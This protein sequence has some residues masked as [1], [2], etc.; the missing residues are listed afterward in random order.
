M[1]SLSVRLGGVVALFFAV[2]ATAEGGSLKRKRSLDTS[3]G[4]YCGIYSLYAA[5]RAVDIDVRFEDLVSSKYVGSIQGSSL[6]EL[7]QAARD[8]GAHAEAFEGMTANSLRTA[9]QPIVLHVRRPGYKTAYAH[10]I[11]FLGT[12]G[13]QARIVD[14]PYGEE[15]IELAELLALWDGVGLVVAREPP[16]R[17]GLFWSSWLEQ[18]IL[19]MVVAVGM[20]VAARLWNRQRYFA[21]YRSPVLGLVIVSVVTAVVWHVF[22]DE[23]YI[24][25]RSARA[26]V[27]AQHFEAALPVITFDE[28]QSLARESDVTMIDARLSEDYERGSIPGAINLPVIAGLSERSE[29]LRNVPSSHRVVV[30]CQ[31]TSCEWADVVASDLVFRGYNNVVVYRGGFSEWQQR[32]RERQRDQE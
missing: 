3:G 27:A 5:L 29:V 21:R 7:R 22:H 16:S 23:G 1:N 24:F 17:L 9:G 18:L 4:P 20:A 11:L 8:F 25:N 32:G 10:W 12:E 28:F 31:S 2:F 15:W 6:A 30:F 19:L 14:P 13:N 26:L